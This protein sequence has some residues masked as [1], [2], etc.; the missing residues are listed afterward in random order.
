MS[1]FALVHGAWHGAWC[2]ERLVG[3]LR[4]RGH[5]VVAPELPSEDPE[6]GLE[7][8]ADT[9]D[10]ALGDAD[11]VVV[12]PHSLGGLVGPV[13]AARRPLRALVYLNALVPEPGLSFGDQLSASDEQV[14]LFEGGREVDEEGRSHWPDREV[15]ARIMYGDL[16]PEDARWAAERLRSQAQRSQTERSPAPPAGLRTES[17]IGTD[18]R[19]VSPAWSRRVARERL[20]VEAI[21]LPTGHFP[22]ISHPEQLAEALAQ[23]DAQ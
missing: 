16:P 12:V 6:L 15:T 19:I 23:L 11:D 22:M 18:D 9:I 13:V 1:I 3:P 14:L 5:E 21:E 10:R 4:D 8:Y 2:W 20:G 7:D 17:I